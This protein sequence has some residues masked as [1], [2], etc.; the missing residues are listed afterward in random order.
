MASLALIPSV[1]YT[2][3]PRA[4][5]RIGLLSFGGPAGQIALTHCELVKER[6]WIS[7]GDFL[8]ALNFCYMLGSGPINRI[9]ISAGM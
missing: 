5:T 1:A 6:K 2:D 4:F 9:P 7:E 8:R 3:L